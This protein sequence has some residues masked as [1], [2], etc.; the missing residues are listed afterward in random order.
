MPEATMTD[1]TPQP[2]RAEQPAPG[3][4]RRRLSAALKRPASRPQIT[5][6]VLL[7]VLGF[8]AVVQVRSNE[9]DDRYVGARQ[10]ELITLINNLSLASRR[11]EQEINQLEQTRNSL[12]NDTEARRTA[13]DRAKEQADTLAVLAGTIPAV[14]PGIRITITDPS[15]RVATQQLLDGLEE[16][17]DAGAEAMEINDTVRVVAQTSL[18]DAS[19]GGVVVD[20]TKLKAPYVI[21]VIGEPHTLAT[22]LSFSGGFSFEVHEADGKV[23]V[24]QLDHVEVASV[25]APPK[26]RY[27]DAE[28]AQ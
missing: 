21:D 13:L 1:Q 17:R 28:P 15:H 14:G 27:A 8:A 12:E 23:R 11:A 24:E 25:V 9:K 6:A 22:A 2:P 5:V 18:R 10:G 26:P 16:L 7:A 3:A 4:G 20:G 19:G